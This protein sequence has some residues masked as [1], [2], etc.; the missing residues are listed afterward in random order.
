M[1]L[2]VRCILCVLYLELQ[3]DSTQLALI[4]KMQLTTHEY[5][6]SF[7]SETATYAL[8]REKEVLRKKSVG[9]QLGIEPGLYMTQV[10]LVVPRQFTLCC[11]GISLACGLGTRLTLT[12]QYTVYPQWLRELMWCKRNEHVHSWEVTLGSW[13]LCCGWFHFQMCVLLYWI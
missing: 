8:E 10:T 1:C 7:P 2:T 11:Q 5:G 9:I 4:S 12:I 3:G 6:I 13:V